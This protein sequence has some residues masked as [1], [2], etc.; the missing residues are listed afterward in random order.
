VSKYIGWEQVQRALKRSWREL[1]S[2][3]YW[4]RVWTRGRK[5]GVE[6]DGRGENQ[7]SRERE[8]S[9]NERVSE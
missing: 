3:Q 8:Q 9:V 1:L 6:G 2:G 5:A 7:E 4:Q